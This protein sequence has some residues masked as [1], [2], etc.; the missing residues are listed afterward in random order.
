MQPRICPALVLL[1]LDQ[2]SGSFYI[3]FRVAR[4]FSLLDTLAG[5]PQYVVV[6]PIERKRYLAFKDL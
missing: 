6:S 3:Y 5:A 2:R 1:N 4:P